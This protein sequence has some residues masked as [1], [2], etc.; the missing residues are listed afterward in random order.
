MQAQMQAIEA[1]IAFLK[2]KLDFSLNIDALP[3]SEGISIEIMPGSSGKPSLN[4]ESQLRTIPLLFMSKYKQQTTAFENLLLIG[5][6]LSKTKFSTVIFSSDVQI[7]SA[8]VKTEASL[9]GKEGDYWI[10]SMIAEI[11]INF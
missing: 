3:V 8:E 11:K 7:L 6:L 10:Y 4:L 2:T 9:V 1:I 5:N